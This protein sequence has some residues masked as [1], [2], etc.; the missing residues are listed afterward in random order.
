MQGLAERGLYRLLIN[1]S[2][3]K[4]QSS[5]SSFLSYISSNQPLSM[6]SFYHF[7]SA[8][9]TDVASETVNLKTC[10]QTI[11]SPSTK[12]V[13]KTLIFHKR[14]GHPSTQVLLHM[15]KN[16]KSISIP[17]YQMHQLHQTTCE[18]CQMGKVYKLHFP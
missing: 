4:S 5:S 18:A 2:S 1:S 16:I 14:F 15:L 10:Y 13:N 17:T 12:S 6:L 3:S 11:V 7:D 8:G 9:H